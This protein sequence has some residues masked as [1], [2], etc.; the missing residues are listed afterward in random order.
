VAPHPDVADASR[1][2]EL[3]VSRH[4]DP[5][6]EQ[7]AQAVKDRKEDGK[8]IRLRTAP[9]TR[10]NRRQNPNNRRSRSEVQS[11][12]LVKFRWKFSLD[13]KNFCLN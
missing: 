6:V 9:D 5:A 4:L 7:I 13:Y 1:E 3:V 12:A 2:D 8:G 11:S 10:E